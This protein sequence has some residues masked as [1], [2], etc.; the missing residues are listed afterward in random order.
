MGRTGKLGGRPIFGSDAPKVCNNLSPQNFKRKNEEKHV[1]TYIP[2]SS[3]DVVFGKGA[4]IRS[5]SLLFFNWIV[6]GLGFRECRPL[7]ENWPFRGGSLAKSN[8][9]FTNHAER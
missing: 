3:V 5:N 8:G 9:E 7:G 2:N 6:C 4:S 1:N